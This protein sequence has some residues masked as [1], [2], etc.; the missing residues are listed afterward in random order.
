MGIVVEDVLWGA[1]LV[2]LQ[3]KSLGVELEA[4]LTHET[5][6]VALLTTTVNMF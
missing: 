6:I 1:G 4:H 2:V 5:S 3:F